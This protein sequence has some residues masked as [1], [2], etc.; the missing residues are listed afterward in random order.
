MLIT[1]DALLSVDELNEIRTLLH[2]AAWLD[3]ATTAGPQAARVK[4]NQQVALNDPALPRLQQLVLSAL[5]RNQIFHS[6][7]L[8]LKLLPPMFNRY[9]A[10][11]NSY[12]MHIDNAMRVGSDGD[13]V[14][15]DISCTLFLSDPEGYEGGQLVIEESLGRRSVKLAAGSVV[16][17][18]SSYLHEVTPVKSGERMACFMFIQSMVRSAEQRRILFDIDQ[19]VS[20]LG[21]R[22]G[23]SS[24][25]LALTGVYHNLLRLWAES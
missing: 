10:V 11:A 22:H 18:P 19:A 25:I 5:R 16:I 4:N 7:V 1:I 12:G 2:G 20:M 24:E 23:S 9:A 15:T 21:Q 17:Y 8:P 6:A 13:H 3:G 14:R